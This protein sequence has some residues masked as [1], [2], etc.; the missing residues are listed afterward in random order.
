[1]KLSN[2]TFSSNGFTVT[3]YQADNLVSTITECDD[4][5]VC[6]V[7]CNAFGKNITSVRVRDKKKHTASA[8]RCVNEVSSNTSN[9]IFLNYPTEY[10]NEATVQIN[11]EPAESIDFKVS[12]GSIQA[13]IDKKLRTYAACLY[14]NL[15]SATNISIEG[16]RNELNDIIMNTQ[17]QLSNGDLSTH[18]ST[19]NIDTVDLINFIGANFVSN[20]PDKE[21]CPARETK[22][23]YSIDNDDSMFKIYQNWKTRMT[24]RI[25]YNETEHAF[26]TLIQDLETKKRALIKTFKID[27]IYSMSVSLSNDDIVED[28][29]TIFYNDN[30]L[31][32]SNKY[33]EDQGIISVIARST[34]MIQI[35]T[36]DANTVDVQYVSDLNFNTLRSLIAFGPEY[37]DFGK[38]GNVEDMDMRIMS[39]MD[40]RYHMENYRRLYTGKDKSRSVYFELA[41]QLCYL[42]NTMHHYH[43]ESKFKTRFGKDLADITMTRYV[44]L[45]SKIALGMILGERSIENHFENLDTLTNTLPLPDITKNNKEW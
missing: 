25:S 42:T 31:S 13:N 41:P 8:V 29:F 43:D 22:I 39:A 21:P 23:S 44:N 14:P 32:I 5:T 4:K 20:K 16:Y 27:D 36:I 12:P 19:V 38:I 17:I 28:E 45:M 15:P 30:S 40:I 2:K 11:S 37:V 6:N 26:V 3:E 9:T 34:K 33:V 35:N 1:M 7:N 24:V 10:N 18:I